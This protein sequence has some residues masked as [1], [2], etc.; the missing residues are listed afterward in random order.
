MSRPPPTRYRVEQEIVEFEAEAV[1]LGLEGGR[2]VAHVARDLGFGETN[3]RSWVRQARIDRGGR[4]GLATEEQ[5]ELFELRREMTRL[6][7]ERE[8]P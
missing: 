1:A 6:R 5:A 8:L 4:P 2:P 7:I 3:L